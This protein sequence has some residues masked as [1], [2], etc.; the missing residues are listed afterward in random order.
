VVPKTISTDGET[1]TFQI[2]SVYV[3][4]NASYTFSLTSLPV[5]VEEI[6]DLTSVN[7][8]EN[9]HPTFEVFPN[10]ARETL[11]IRN[12]ADKAERYLI[13]DISGKLM[14]ELEIEPNQVRRIDLRSWENG[15][16]FIR[17]KDQL[18]TQKIV[19]IR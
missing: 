2:D 6:T 5:F 16:Y 9:D 1:A 19:V 13:S 11:G 17:A 10:P 7:Y 15:I 8:Q 12:H 14:E 3:S 18:K 4:A